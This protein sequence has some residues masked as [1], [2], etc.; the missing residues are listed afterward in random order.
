MS[1]QLSITQT[2][3]D[4]IKDSRFLNFKAS[5]SSCPHDTCKDTAWSTAGI[6]LTWPTIR[7]STHIRQKHS[8]KTNSELMEHLGAIFAQLSQYFCI[9]LEHHVD[10]IIAPLLHIFLHQICYV[11]ALGKDQMPMWNFAVVFTRLRFTCNVLHVRIFFYEDRNSVS[12]KYQNDTKSY[13]SSESTKNRA[14]LDSSPVVP[15]VQN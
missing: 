10:K 13:H 9:A 4:W 12:T 15:V 2:S 7:T 3:V 6:V 8:L 14:R 11:F 1:S 5:S